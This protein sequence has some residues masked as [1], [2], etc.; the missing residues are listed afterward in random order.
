MNPETKTSLIL[1]LAD[2]HDQDAWQEFESVYR[3]VIYHAAQQRGLQHADAED[4]VQQV[5]ASIARALQARPHDS[6]RAQFRTWLFRVIQNSVLNHVQRRR[7]DRGSGRT[8]VLDQL[9]QVANPDQESELLAA[10]YQKS[11]FRWAA[12]K[13]ELEFHP[14][15][16]RAFWLT[17]VE[18][19]SCETAAREL[20]KE[21][22]SIY[23][24]RS[25]VVR[26]LRKKIE[27]FDD[28]CQIS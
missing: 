20:N 2:H 14:E 24:A 26:R 11:V 28:S 13:I 27:E 12:E 6:R 18:G 19:Y 10:E 1:R 8:S 16:W 15:T 5:L 4:V 25:R 23:A 7:P 9:T 17:M 22:G 21:V 3:P